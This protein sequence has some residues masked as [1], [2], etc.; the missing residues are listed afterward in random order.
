MKSDSFTSVMVYKLNITLVNRSTQCKMPT[1]TWA[2]VPR[3]RKKKESTI[4]LFLNISTHVGHFETFCLVDD[5]Y[6][7]NSKCK[8]FQ[9]VI[10]SNQRESKLYHNVSCSWKRELR[11][12]PWFH[13]L[14]SCIGNWRP[15]VAKWSVQ[16]S[17]NSTWINCNWG[18]FFRE[19]TRM[20]KKLQCYLVLS[21]HPPICYAQC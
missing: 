13:Y 9:N 4:S 16:K 3:N 10:E 12:N 8:G 2:P 15:G 5:S 1:V 11:I 19:T 7:F 20:E 21:N 14:G 6:K 18:S 17:H